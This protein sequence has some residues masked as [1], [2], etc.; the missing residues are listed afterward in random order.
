MVSGGAISAW[1]SRGILSP[2]TLVCGV[3]LLGHLSYEMARTPLTP[4]FAKH[5]GAPV[6]GI[7][8]IVAAVTLTGIVVKLPAGAL[9]DLFGF[10]R[11]M[12]AGARVK[13]TGPFVYLL[14]FSWP[15]LLIVRFYHGLATALY[16]P[17]ASALVSK[18]YPTERGRRLGLYN[19]S[20]NSGVVL[21][22]VVGGFVLA[23]TATNFTIAFIVS[24]AIGILALLVMTRVPKDRLTLAPERT[25]GRERVLLR[26][27]RSFSG[28]F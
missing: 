3:G 21:G 16:A 8:V 4:L 12:M 20:E 23:A 2:L 13:A 28:S 19:A 1:T 22:P 6:Q 14:A 10:R 24:G 9:S 18:A 5:L 17:P 11:L 27:G 26:P 25:P 15:G 7:G